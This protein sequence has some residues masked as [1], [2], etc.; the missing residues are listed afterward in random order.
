MVRV[1]I[2]ESERD[3]DNADAQW[4]NEQVRGY[5]RTHGTLPCLRVTVDEDHAHITLISANCARSGG[6]GG[7]GAPQWSRPEAEVLEL[8]KRLH[9]DSSDWTQGNLVAF[10]QQARRLF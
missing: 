8:W 6:G 1:K 3:L 4:V 5:E 10:I 2:D 7:G 9:L